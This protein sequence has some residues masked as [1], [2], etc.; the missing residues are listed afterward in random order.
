MP[1]P[2]AGSG[3]WNKQYINEQVGFAL[4]SKKWF[5]AKLKQKKIVCSV[6]NECLGNVDNWGI[7]IWDQNGEISYKT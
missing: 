4:E 6:E 7:G 5:K 2:P 1:F 3:H